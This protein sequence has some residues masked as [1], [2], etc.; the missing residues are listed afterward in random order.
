MAMKFHCDRCGD[1]TARKGL[2]LVHLGDDDRGATP[3]QANQRVELCEHC[4]IHVRRELSPSSVAHA[5]PRSR[6][7]GN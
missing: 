6:S 2:V 5:A 4:L 7:T 3:H 1:V